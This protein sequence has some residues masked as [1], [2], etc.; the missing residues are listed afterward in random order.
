MKL[1][2]L[3]FLMLSLGFVSVTSAQYQSTVSTVPSLIPNG[4]NGGITF[5]V[6]SALSIDI[7]QL[8]C[9]F[10]TGATSANVWVRI[11]GVEHQPG[12]INISTVNGWWQVITSAS[13]SGADNTSLIPINFNTTVIPVQANV[14]MGFYIEGNTRYQTGYPYDQTLFSDGIVS[15][16]VAD[17][18]SYGGSKPIP[19]YNPRRFTG[20]VTYKLQ[21]T[22]AAN[23]VGAVAINAPSSP[24]SSGVNSVMAIINNLGINQ[25]NSV[26]V[27]W[28]V[29]GIIQ[30][31]VA[32]TS[33]IDTIGGTGP[34]LVNVTL[35]SFTFP[36]GNNTIK[37]WTSLPN[38]Q[39]DTFNI[40]DSVVKTMYFGAPFSGTYTIGGVNADFTSFKQALDILYYYGVSG[41]VIFNVNPG[42]YTEQLTFAGDPAG[43]STVN[44]ITFQSA[45]GDS[46]SVTL[47]FQAT[48]GT[49]N[50]VVRFNGASNITFKKMTLYASGLSNSYVF[51]LLSGSKRITITNCIL[52]S[53]TISGL[54]TTGCIYSDATNVGVDYLI[55]SNNVLIGG[56]YSIYWYGSSTNKKKHV[57]IENNSII[58]YHKY[59]IRCYYADS[60][61]IRYNS[62]INKTTS[63]TNYA[64]DVY[65]NIGA[66][67]V[68]G[69]KIH[70]QGTGS[71]YGITSGYKFV[72]NSAPMLVAN[73]FVSQV[74]STGTV[75]AIY[76]ETTNYVNLYYNSVSVGNGSTGGGS[77]LY[78]TS[79]S[80]LNII[81][82]SLANFGGG[83]AIYTSSTTNINNC[84]Y[85][86]LF[87]T[88]VSLGYWGTTHATLAA[89]KT[90]T[91]KDLNSISLDPEYISF[92]DLHTNSSG[93]WHTGT[94]LV[95]VPLDIDK[96]PR[97][98]TTP[99]IGADE[100]TAFT[101]DAGILQ[102][103]EPLS[104]SPGI[105][106]NVKVKVRN[107]GVMAITGVTINWKING[108]AQIPFQYT[109]SLGAGVNQE[110]TIGTYTF[111]SGVE[112]D[113]VFWSTNPGGIPDPHPANDTLKVFDFWT[114]FSGIFTIGPS[115]LDHFS[116][117]AGAVSTLK[118][119][120]VSGPVTFIVA[121]NSGPYT[122]GVNF[123]GITGISA[124]NTITFNG[125]GNIINESSP[126]YIL[127]FS[128]VSYITFNNFQ[129]AVSTPSKARFAILIRNG[130]TKL[131]F[132]NNVIDLGITS[133]S[134]LS[135]GIVASGS[136]TI[137]TEVGNNA[138]YLTI[139]NNTIIGGYYGIILNGYSP[140]LYNY[141]HLISNNILTNF[142]FYG[143]YLVNADSTVVSG[144]NISRATR[145]SLTTFQGIYG[146]SSRNLKIRKNQIHSSGTGSYSAFPIWLVSSNN[147]LGFETEIVNNAI[148]NIPAT[149]ALNGI[150]VSGSTI[151]N[152]FI[153]YNTVNLN[154]T[155]GAG[156]VR[157]VY[158]SVAPQNCKLFNNVVNI[159]GS[160]TGTKH[161]IYVSSTSSTFAA[162]NNL[163]FLSAGGTAN[164]V[165]Y[166]LGNKT[167]LP[168]WQIATSMDAN[169]I[170]VDPAFLT[171]EGFRTI[172]AVLWNAGVPITGVTDDID[173]DL[174]KPLTPCIGADEYSSYTNDASVLQMTEPLMA[175]SGIASNVK[176]KIRNNGYMAFTGVTVSWSVNGVAQTPFSFASSIAPDTEQEVTLGTY[177]FGYGILYN[178]VFITS[179]PGGSADQ[180]PANDTLKVLG[181]KASM[182]GIFTI[183]QSPIHDF[184]TIEA[185]VTALKTSGVCG[186]V[187]I[188]VAANSGPYN[189]G[190]DFEGIVG[191]SAT[192]TIT[193]NGNGNIIKVDTL[194]YI[195]RFS[196]NSYITINNFELVDTNLSNNTIGI[197]I[198]NGSTNLVFNN[199]LIKLGITSTLSSAGIAATGSDASPH[200]YGINARYLTITNNTIIGGY[201]GIILMGNSSNMENFG[202]N[203]A[204]NIVKDFNFHGI[205][206]EG[207]D[208]T[209][210]SANNISRPNRSP[211]LF[212][213]IEAYTCS[214]IKLYNNIVH[215]S[216][217]GSYSCY[218]FEINTSVNTPGYET[219]LIN[220]VVYNLSTSGKINGIRLSG[221]IEHVK[222]SHNTIHVYTN[223][224]NNVSGVYFATAPNNL[225]LRNNLISINGTGT[226]IKY[227]IYATFT[228][229]TFTSDNNVLHMGATGGL[230]NYTGFWNDTIC[231]NLASWSSVS[232]KDFNSSDL[233]PVFASVATGNLTPLSS[234]IDNMGAPV[235][236]LTDLNNAPRSLTTP[237]AGAVEFVGIGSD[238]ALDGGSM[239][240]GQCLNTNDS[241]FFTITNAI[242]GAINFAVNP[243]TIFW[244]VTGPVNSNGT[245][246]LNSGTIAATA[247]LTV[248]GAGV[249]LS[250]PGVYTLS[251]YLGANTV[252][253]FQ[254]NDTLQNVASL[255][256]INPFYVEPDIVFVPDLTQTVNI[257][258]KSLFFPA[259]D[260]YFS[261]VSYAKSTAG[262]PVGGWPPYLTARDYVEITGA[263][264]THLGGYTLESWSDSALINSYI[265]PTGTFVGSNGTAV[266]AI[267]EPE[268]GVPNPAYYY[269]HAN[270]SYN[271][272]S[273]GTSGHILKDSSGNIV[274]AV[275]Y[276]NFNFPPVANVP[277][278]EW[279]NPNPAS[280][281]S[282]CGIRLFGSDNNTGSN[283]TIVSA[284]YPQDPN[285]VNAGTVVPVPG[286]PTGFTWS[287][288]GVVFATN[289]NNATVG[290]WT[291]SGVYHYVASYATPCGSL[292]DTVAVFVGSLTS[293]PDTTICAGDS[294]LL[295]VWFPGTGPWTLVVSDGAGIDTI[296]GI[297][298]SPYSTY[299][300]P[301][302]TTVYSLL[303]FKEGNG[304]Y[305]PSYLSC[306]VTVLPLPIVSLASFAPVCI[307]DTP[308]TLTGGL[309][310]GGTYSGTGIVGG[311]FD[312][313]TAGFGTHTI[314]YSFINSAGCSGSEVK[315]I[316]VG[317]VPAF[318]LT[319]DHAICEGDSTTLT[320]SPSGILNAI[321][322]WSNGAITPLI[323]VSPVVSTT[324]I[325]AVTDT[326]PNC[327]GV[328]SV[329][330]IV[331][332]AS[333]AAISGAQDTICVYHT[334]TLDAG[335]GFASYSWST[336]ATTQTIM[337]DGA[338]IGH[339]NTMSYTVT[340]TNSF[341]C[342][343][344]ATV[345][346]TADDC[347]GLSDPDTA[348]NIRLWPNP[349]NGNFFIGVNGI[350]GETK[351]IISNVTGKI[352][353][354]ET[355]HQGGI[356]VKELNFSNKAPGIYTVR[357]QSE[358]QVVIKQFVIR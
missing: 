147:T 24:A 212:V 63:S 286:T 26:N 310:L 49:N 126:G 94:P 62:I 86:N 296:S 125:N 106:V 193:F 53:D 146:S 302:S 108:V 304:Q 174:R 356:T 288:N 237:D 295:Q 276:G 285:S 232:L 328:D 164:Y 171:P 309:P 98:P 314:T 240:T 353:C 215:S 316:L 102:L 268:G 233:N 241:V 186:Q 35:G 252:N 92:N 169:S 179:N 273:S 118:T 250:I 239:A 127:R 56:Y 338:A 301:T 323:T 248:G 48:S 208:T 150:Y 271:F 259:G 335:A 343:A 151:K 222:I 82:N 354:I 292:S 225:M 214:N 76:L 177:T 266:V 291:T 116:S 227:C 167:T 9:V 88:G 205:Y 226:G 242:G 110:V 123:E 122:G 321:Y 246:I 262:Q 51:V 207:A 317:A 7:T 3:I 305:V 189:G 337:V 140:I 278:S 234:G 194:R 348:I 272:N 25:I 355:L 37:V 190:I 270:V 249:N 256:I 198:R 89:W 90:A 318:T 217:V 293:I 2:P 345:K 336:G 69:N 245:M 187:T 357:L 119:Y 269:Y 20:G 287:H 244:T 107:Y 42:T 165:G 81:N 349:N 206:L 182:Y 306:T 228:S 281:G 46:T 21:R 220:N 68:I 202:H 87:T 136:E 236:V 312:P 93:M 96:Q 185:A 243:H 99:C 23:D 17:N 60:V 144:N 111:L 265:F 213:G 346:I 253:L 358:S 178:L 329:V 351:L 307:Y 235:G 183:G 47:M 339:G 223:A 12:Q 163:Y 158:F 172:S 14:R 284:A 303:S 8:S 156:S 74:G 129:I 16:I 91:G 50:W 67:E 247:S 83:Y 19:P 230:A 132:S 57:L 79:G 279:S 326:L 149:G 61:Y 204:G 162:N 344:A 31:P 145:A 148:Y 157:G 95:P 77:A 103:T 120:G 320:V 27:H 200:A 261:E 139:T 210:V 289:L 275:G 101:N 114:S 255:N 294:A 30:P 131:T 124:V 29:N 211:S 238:I 65:Y 334:I 13:I 5:E 43:V 154:I 141:G 105:A 55:V 66:S 115:V 44:T 330:V 325:V 133:T 155:S 52:M 299:V 159:Q 97:H 173:G 170:S 319:A 71:Q 18:A 311:V 195:L 59:G 15:V 78:A 331:N 152:L 216:G 85:N 229:T 180:N 297:L 257:S 254:G 22:G 332:P 45:T 135:A 142:Y 28:S 176:V 104:A 341:G 260:F 251:A 290:P 58:G 134:E 224:A 277:A 84:N 282:T 347:I 300:S 274:D 36:A 188:N 75:Y 340:V 184:S 40:N 201:Y 143:I 196:N 280:P 209:I 41:P 315:Q 313:G 1:L 54:I 231:S 324:Y 113:M 218:P 100:F 64:V 33:M 121:P 11:G 73:N 112:Y 168:D 80:N 283:W 342:S 192:N 161:G 38:N 199:N 175:C 39:P 263:P 4:G 72:S 160:A 267:G 34:N 308:L 298:S 153:Y 350:S 70:L 264:S 166:W 181:F 322:S 130:C 352:L 327:F 203:V 137:P 6:E 221:F 138:Q 191:T 128:N 258:A 117:F 10:T 32:Y 333:V 109:S 219:E 197:L